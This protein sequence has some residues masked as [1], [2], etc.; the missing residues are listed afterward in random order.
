LEQAVARRPRFR[1][2]TPINQEKTDRFGEE[3]GRG[4]NAGKT[5][6]RRDLVVEKF[7]GYTAQNASGKAQGAS[8]AP[9]GAGNGSVDALTLDTLRALVSAN[10]GS[11]LR[12]KLPTKVTAHLGSKHP[13]LEAVRKLAYSVPFLEKLDGEQGLAY[14]AESQVIQAV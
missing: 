7:Y 6:P 14:D 2:A 13:Q 1:L 3:K 8:G 10:G 9:N 5:F 11:L 4:K 12:G